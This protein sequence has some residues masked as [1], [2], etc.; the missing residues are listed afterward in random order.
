MHEWMVADDAFAHPEKDL[1]IGW[2]MDL[3]TVKPNNMNILVEYLKYS[4]C[5]KKIL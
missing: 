5:V 3:E 1:G 4:H 2:A